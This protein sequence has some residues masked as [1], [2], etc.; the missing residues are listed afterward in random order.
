MQHAMRNRHL[1]DANKSDS[2]LQVV[3]QRGREV[4][5][6]HLLVLACAYRQGQGAGR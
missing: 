6:H 4:V 1:T 2:D 3:L 5:A